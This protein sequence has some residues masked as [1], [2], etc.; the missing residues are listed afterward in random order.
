MSDNALTVGGGV[1]LGL[2]A[3]VAVAG[4][5]LRYAGTH[6]PTAEEIGRLKSE[7]DTAGARHAAAVAAPP[8]LP[9][10]ADAVRAARELLHAPVNVWAS[11]GEGRQVALTDLIDETVW[12]D[13]ERAAQ[14]GWA[15]NAGRAVGLLQ[16]GDG[17]F[18]AAR[19][20]DKLQPFHDWHWENRL[21]TWT[22]TRQE[23]YTDADGQSRTRTAYDHHS[24]TA[25]VRQDTVEQFDR[26]QADQKEIVGLVHPSRRRLENLGTPEQRDLRAVLD[27]AT[28]LHGDAVADV[29]R[30]P[31]QLKWSRVLRPLGL[32]AA[33][34]G[35]AALAVEG[36]RQYGS[37]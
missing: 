5:G 16:P 14:H 24:A 33:A 30:A 6:N 1:A 11:N 18:L 17:Q 22:T 9:S 35:A 27:E 36:Y 8:R 13:A 32:T 12:P 21:V 31:A 25:R 28:K 20:D 10:D 23:S 19:T 4:Y 7:M 2:G 15:Q 37:Q 26:F 29:A 34:A 3:G